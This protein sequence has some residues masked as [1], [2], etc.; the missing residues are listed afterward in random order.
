MKGI[1]LPEFEAIAGPVSRE[2]FNR[3]VEFDHVFDEWA[4]KLNLVA[5]GTLD[6]RG[7]RHFLDS[8]QLASLAPEAMEWLDLGSGGGFPGLPLAFLLTDRAGAAID[9]VESNRKK[10]GFLQAMVGRFSLPARVHAVRIEDAAQRIV[11]PEIVTARAL[12]PLPELL[13]LAEPWLAGKSRSLFHKGREYAEELRQSARSW[14]FD[15]IEHRSRVDANSVILEI[16][17]LR[18]TGRESVA[19]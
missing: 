3:I 19:I 11:A 5:Q 12:A 17:N 6:E 13:R 18:R 1:G 14:S 9:L 2:T 15:L 8:V 7:T 4:R 16:W 10:A